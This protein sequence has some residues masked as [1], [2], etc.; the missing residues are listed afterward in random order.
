MSTWGLF[1]RIALKKVDDLK[2]SL[3]KTGMERIDKDL[4][5]G[6]RFNAIVEIPEVDFILGGSDLKIKHP[7]ASNSV[8][9][10]G[11][12]PI[13]DS[14]VH[15]FYLE[16]SDT[17]YMLQIVLDMKKIVEEC[18]LFM[19]YD[20]VYP[21]DWG[22]WLS[23]KDGYIG[24]SVFETKDHTQYFRVWENDDAAQVV[25]ED[26]DGSRLTRVPTVQFIEK[27]YLDPYG[28]VTESIKYDSMLYGRHV[29]DK[30]DEYLLLSAVDEKDGASV[31]IMVGVELQVKSIKVI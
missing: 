14:S 20:V 4:P 13:G 26:K 23:D 22:F 1:K 6:L 9:S 5:L 3:H 18:K 28:E 16:S 8:V 17:I 15:R 12:F 10:Y 25:E 31:Q 7:G 19:P 11:A 29:N 24:L 30:V 27:V 2:D 21:E